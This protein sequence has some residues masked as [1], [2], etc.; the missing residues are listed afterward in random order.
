MEK[1]MSKIYIYFCL[2]KLFVNGL[3]NISMFQLRYPVRQGTDHWVMG[4]NILRAE[5][6]R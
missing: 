1:F 6:V 3:A 5:K 2:L 4:R